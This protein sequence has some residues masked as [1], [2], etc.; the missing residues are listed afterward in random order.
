MFRK[1]TAAALTAM[2]LAIAIGGS[3]FIYHQVN[4]NEDI[5]KIFNDAYC[6]SPF[7]KSADE[8]ASL[9]MAVILEEELT[10]EKTKI[11]RA[12]EKV[13]KYYKEEFNIAI[14]S[15]HPITIPEIPE[16]EN[17][18][19]LPVPAEVKDAN[20]FM[21]LAKDL[22]SL[23]IDGKL[24]A[25]GN[26]EARIIVIQDVDILKEDDLVSLMAHEVA[27]LYYVQNHEHPEKEGCLMSDETMHICPKLRAEIMGYRNRKW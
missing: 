6:A 14:T 8:E 24:R 4:S 21:Y 10:F 7:P 25:G 26:Y 1:K 5:K 13:K 27:H 2:N 11:E 3:Y 19:E 23:V 16:Y 22:E 18:W 15:S 9:S 12:L 20:A 17:H